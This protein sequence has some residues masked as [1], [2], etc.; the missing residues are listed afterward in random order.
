MGHASYDDWPY[1]LWCQS[2][3]IIVLIPI[4]VANF[5][6]NVPVYQSEISPPHNRE[7]LACIEFTKNIVGHAWSAWVDYF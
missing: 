5:R 3:I 4:N 6:A 7:K 1:Q 2:G